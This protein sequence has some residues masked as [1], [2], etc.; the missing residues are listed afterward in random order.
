M[1]LSFKRVGGVRFWRIGRLGGSFYLAKA[2]DVAFSPVRSALT[3]FAA[4]VVTL[5]PVAAIAMRMF[6]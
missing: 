3:G 6:G 4:G 2:S 1:V 5:A